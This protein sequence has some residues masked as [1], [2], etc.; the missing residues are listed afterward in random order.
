[1]SP[2]SVLVVRHLTRYRYATPVRFGE[3][4]M[5]LHP[6]EG[7]DQRVIQARLTITP[8]PCELSFTTD[9]FGNLHGVARFDASGSE[10]C[11]E[12]EALVEQLPAP[13]PAGRIRR[14]SR[15]AH[16]HTYSGGDAAERALAL[17]RRHADPDGRIEAWATDFLPP[18]GGVSALDALIAMNAAIRREVRYARRLERGLQSPAETLDRGAG[19]CRDQAVLM[20]EAAR[21]L[22]LAARFASG[23]VHCPPVPGHAGRRGGGHT[24]AWAR[25]HVPGHGW[26][27][28]DPTNG[29]VGAEGL[30]RVAVVDDP[31]E[32]IPLHGAYFGSSADALGMDVE[33]DVRLAEPEAL[34]RVALVAA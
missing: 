25:I 18:A 9:A 6:Q 7:E 27:D 21:A 31:A 2:M 33:V 11:F 17:R 3:H 19:A 4:R 23:Y 1:M 5:L 30:V 22:G 10:L 20:I 13:A 12:S 14:L 26:M 29:A 34:E 15:A 8:E 28:F 24:H 32:A 16:P